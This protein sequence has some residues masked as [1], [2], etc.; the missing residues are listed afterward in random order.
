MQ[1]GAGAG[2]F[3]GHQPCLSFLHSL[4]PFSISKPESWTAGLVG[5]GR[6]QGSPE[7]G[8]AGREHEHRSISDTCISW[9]IFT[10]VLIFL[11]LVI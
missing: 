5:C 10:L 11:H 1:R 4:L 7:D 8:R 9:D 6:R 3:D 2:G